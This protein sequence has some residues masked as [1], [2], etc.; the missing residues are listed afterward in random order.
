MAVIKDKAGVK[1]INGDKGIIAHFKKKNRSEV[2]TQEMISMPQQSSALGLPTDLFGA[3]TEP[4]CAI[5]VTQ[6][7]SCEDDNTS[8]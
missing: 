5:T 3:T 6:T 1:I 8:H 2:D 7:P 4:G